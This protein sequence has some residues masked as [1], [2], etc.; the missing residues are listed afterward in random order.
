MHQLQTL[1]FLKNAAISKPTS[2]WKNCQRRD[3][4]LSH[5]SQYVL[6]Q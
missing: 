3:W 6:K 4:I 5:E 1:P 2:F